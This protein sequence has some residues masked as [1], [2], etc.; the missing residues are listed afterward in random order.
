MITDRQWLARAVE[1]SR[2]CPPTSRAYDVGAI[3]V[4]AAGIEL[5]R[6]YSREGDPHVHAEESALGK[7][8]PADPR[9]RT[10]TL[11]STLEPCS[12]R[13]SRPLTCT[14]LI[15]AA[16]IPRVVIAWRE[17]PLLVADCIGVELLTAAGV[18]VVEIPDL[19]GSPGG[20]TRPALS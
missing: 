11:Y 15:L 6:G 12:E 2:S 14:Q 5:S 7:L 1:L 17:P 4:D 3:V 16:G 10:A 13:A 19:P 20:P 8:P 9:L 18:A